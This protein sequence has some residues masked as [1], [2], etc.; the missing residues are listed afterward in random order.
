MKKWLLIIIGILVLGSGGVGTYFLL[1]GNSSC[2]E[3]NYEVTRRESTCMLKGYEEY[4]CTVCGDS[5]KEYIPPLGHDYEDTIV[6]PTCLNE[7]YTIHSC[8]RCTNEYTDSYVEAKGHDFDIQ[9]IEPT[10]SEEGNSIYTCKDCGFKKIADNVPT[11]EHEYEETI[12]EATCEE[13][14]YTIF[15]CKNCDY[16]YEGNVTPNKGHDYNEIVIEPTCIEEGYTIFECKNCD[17]SYVGD[18]TP[19]QDHEYLETIIEPTCTERGY[20]IFEC[21]DCLDSYIGDYVYSIGHS[22]EPV[23]P[24]EPGCLEDGR[25]FGYK[26]TKCDY[27]IGLKPIPAVGH[28]IVIDDPI[29]PTVEDFGYTEGSHCD[30]C[31]QVFDEP[32]PIPKLLLLTVS[33]TPEAFLEISPSNG[34]V[35]GDKIFVSV[36]LSEGYTFDGWYQ[37]DELLTNELTYEF[38]MPN[39]S[40]E[41]TAVAIPNQ[42]NLYVSIDD[43]E[44]G[45][46]NISDQQV[47]VNENIELSIDLN[48]GYSFV[49]WSLNSK[50]IS[51]DTSFTLKCKPNDMNIKAITELCN[52]NVYIS[53]TGYGSLN[54][55]SFQCTIKDS[56]T[57]RATPK[58]Y[59][60]FIGWFEG[61]QLISSEQE[62]VLTNVSR[63]YRIKAVFDQINAYIHVVAGMNGK[64]SGPSEVLAGTEVTLIAEPN[65]SY[66]FVGWYINDNLI[67]TE[68]E[69]I[70]SFE[71]GCYIL[72]A[73]FDT[74]GSM[75][76][77]HYEDEEVEEK[78]FDVDEYLTPYAYKEG[79]TFEGWYIDDGT[80]EI[81]LDITCGYNV[82]VYPKFTYK[83]DI[84]S[85]YQNL[86]LPYQIELYSR[87][88]L[89]GEPLDEYVLIYDVDGNPIPTEI[90]KGL[91]GYY[92]L[93]ADFE[94]GK[95]YTFEIISDKIFALNDLREY[96]FSFIRDEVSEITFNENVVI[97]EKENIYE[98]TENG[99]ICY[100]IDTIEVGNIIYCYDSEDGYLKVVETV[101]LVDDD[102]YEITFGDQEITDEDIN[103]HLN[104]KQSDLEFNL[105]NATTN[106]DEEE[107]LLLLSELV[108]EAAQ[109]NELTGKLKMLSTRNASF[110]FEEP[111][112][113]TDYKLSFKEISISVTITINGA[114]KNSKGNIIDEFAIKVFFEVKNFI[115]IDCDLDF[116]VY[117]PKLNNFNLTITNTTIVNYNLDLIYGTHGGTNNYDALEELLVDYENTLAEKKEL[118]FNLNSKYEKR[119]EAVTKTISI[120]IP[121]TPLV[122]DLAVTPFVSFTVIGQ[123]DINTSV[124]MT[125]EVSLVYT[126][127]EFKVLLNSETSKDVTA[128]AIAYIH[129]EAGFNLDIS[130]YIKHLQKILNGNLNFEAGPYV[131]ASGALKYENGDSDL[132]GY[133]EWGCFYDYKAQITVIG[134]TIEKDPD[135]EYNKIG[136][137]GEYFLVLGFQ[138]ETSS[139]R[140]NSTLINLY[141]DLGYLNIYGYR[142]DTLE[143]FRGV[144]DKEYYRFELEENNY[145][146]I[147]HD[148]YLSLYNIPPVPVDVT[149]YIYCGDIAVKTVVITVAPYFENVTLI[150]PTKGTISSDKSTAVQGEYVMFNYYSYSNDIVI[151]NWIINGEVYDSI[152]PTIFIRMVSGGLEIEIELMDAGDV[153]YIYDKD[154]FALVT[155]NPSATFMLMNDINFGGDSVTELC[156]D[157]PFSGRFY[158][159]GHTI[160]NVDLQITSRYNEDYG[161]LDEEGRNFNW[162]YYQNTASFFGLCEKATFYDLHFDNVTCIY[163]LTATKS[164]YIEVS[165]LAYK[166]NRCSFE[167]CSVNN[168]NI[169]LDCRENISGYS[170][171]D[172]ETH[173]SAFVASL[174]FSRV[175]NV[176]LTNINVNVYS[177]AH[178]R[179]GTAVETSLVGGL[180]CNIVGSCIIENCYIEGQ[181]N[182]ECYQSTKEADIY[183]GG[184]AGSHY[185]R[186]DYFGGSQIYLDNCIIDVK[187]EGQGGTLYQ[188][189]VYNFRYHDFEASSIQKTLR[190]MHDIYYNESSYS[191]TNIKLDVG[192]IPLRSSEFRSSQFIFGIVQFDPNAWEL[193]GGSL[194]IK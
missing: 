48:P 20:T 52:Y 109:I 110:M 93:T 133:V 11:I 53:T 61:D 1:N 33:G 140:F 92:H 60:T 6:E 13:D 38:T 55:S 15:D 82:D 31:G 28:N 181:L 124:T 105:S 132:M 29:A 192:C 14:G 46:I 125:N 50:I 134:K 104:V 154:D 95:T 141:E 23:E 99:I 129:A 147:I 5:Y 16:S 159:N 187:M 136:S 85:F 90:T 127:G 101:T 91:G 22:V 135:K 27:T 40:C 111:K 12:I 44:A 24:L 160:S 186:D 87:L 35:E 41:I 71:P 178:P 182:A 146:T 177:E 21:K 170:R 169:D 75:I 65:P 188:S 26:C 151:K 156:W 131:E 142:L 108:T 86:E 36:T 66:V 96:T 167:K 80:F 76:T 145:I 81:P 74:E 113:E 193:S 162:H 67:S 120:P 25:T 32:Q 126:K 89:V 130:L 161:V 98:E 138:N 153:Y 157:T 43:T 117:L 62:F 83:N 69:F 194:K 49:G 150:Q 7:G 106:G 19:I 144:V 183:L 100:S 115:N 171:L 8:T 118:P 185:D 10:C 84:T 172:I 191:S 121:H 58:D 155:E 148:Y 103:F 107:A 77:Y 70:T 143:I 149:L 122:I 17:H 97:I 184:I 9:V 175:K 72:Y 73:M 114:R 45:Q 190:N 18:E 88:E 30:R 47:Y 174:Q 137:I 2:D 176:S 179:F 180:A 51:R 139:Y 112:V 54:W 63:D 68:E 123:M 168:V 166:A 152:S 78:V 34:Y 158:G 94:E 119:L 102:V 3:H 57:L 79:Y 4:T 163:K 56:T 173:A 42:Y 164:T 39:E 128:Y 37:G 165:V 59:C 116:Q 64:A 189:A